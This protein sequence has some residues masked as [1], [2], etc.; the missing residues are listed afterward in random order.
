[1]DYRNGEA[2]EEGEAGRLNPW[3][4]CVRTGEVTVLIVTI[5]NVSTQRQP[6][7]LKISRVQPTGNMG[8]EVCIALVAEGGWEKPVVSVGIWLALEV[9]NIEGS[10]H[11]RLDLYE[12]QRPLHPKGEREREG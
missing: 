4:P 10:H 6:G 9:V 1:M 11:E 12:P 5:S 2:V 7:Y 3:D 8:R